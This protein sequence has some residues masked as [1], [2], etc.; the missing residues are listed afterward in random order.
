MKLFEYDKLVKLVVKSQTNYKCILTLL[1]I[2]YIFY[3]SVR[4]PIKL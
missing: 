4:P 3:K 1:S 2:T